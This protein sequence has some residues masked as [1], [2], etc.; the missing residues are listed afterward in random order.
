MIIAMGRPVQEIWPEV[1]NDV[2]P[3][4]DEYVLV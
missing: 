1:Y 2:K 3:L 4:F